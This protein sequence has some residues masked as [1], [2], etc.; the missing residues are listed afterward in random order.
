MIIEKDNGTTHRLI[1]DD[2][3]NVDGLKC[4]LILNDPP[5]GSRRNIGTK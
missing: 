2:F 5:F 1:N 3:F 4:D